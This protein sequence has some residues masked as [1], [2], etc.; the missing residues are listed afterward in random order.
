MNKESIERVRDTYSRTARRYEMILRVYRVLGVDLKK[1]RE[2]A[3]GR[4]PP[5]AG[6]RILD[7][8]VGTGA[9]LQY[10]VDKYPNYREIVGIDYTPEMLVR[11]KKRIAENRWRNISVRLI[12][13]REMSGHLQGRFDLIISTYSLSIIPDAVLVLDQIQRVLD[14]QGYLLLLDCQKF[15]GL[16]RILNPMAIL[17]S[18]RLGGSDVTY[19]VRVSDIAARMFRPLSRRLMYSGMF[20]EDIYRG[21]RV[22]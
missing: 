14:Q 12:D 5:L 13:A 10:L 21:T 2:E 11:A 6:P 19:S 1:W 15:K 9:N 3:F 17:L 8:A 18:T 22:S 20:Y 16:L 4:L 7:L